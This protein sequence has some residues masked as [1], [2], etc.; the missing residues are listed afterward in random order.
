LHAQGVNQD[1][2]GDPLGSRVPDIDVAEPHCFATLA[3][4]PGPVVGRPALNSQLTSVSA[5]RFA[6]SIDVMHSPLLVC[7]AE[8]IR[9]DVEEI[10]CNRS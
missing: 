6:T 1:E 3:H 7:R 9:P 10:R 2:R 8:A 5:S 4:W